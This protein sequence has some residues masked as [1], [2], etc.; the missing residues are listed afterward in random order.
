MRPPPPA[1]VLPSRNE[2]TTIAAVTAAV[3]AALDN[4][5][6][7]I[8]H[9]DSS[10]THETAEAF[11]RTSTRA[12]KVT[13]TGLPRGKGIQILRALDW[14][15]SSTGPVLIADTDTRDPDPTIYK[16]LL[17]VVSGGAVMAIADYPRFWD[18]AN[19]TNH[20]ARPLIDAALGVDIPQ[21]LAGDLA[22]SSGTLTTLP[23]AR[24]ALA[25]PEATAVEGYGIDA[26]LLLT[27]ARTGTVTPVRVNTPKRH[28]ASFE[29]LAAIYAQV[30]PILL[31]MTAVRPVSP[32]AVGP[33]PVY[34]ATFRSVDLDRLR[35]MVAALD[36]VAPYEP[37]YD[38]HP[39]PMPLA[40]AW[41]AVRT[42]TSPTRA[43]CTLWPHYV[44]R[45][46]TWLI[47]Q[48]GAGELS[49]S[50]TRLKAA[51]SAPA[52]APARSRT[53]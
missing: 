52:P 8:V 4:P 18:E 27:A 35:T 22:L 1:A 20:I 11:S 21:P 5:K 31:A 39:W 43:A 50:H 48:P 6:A 15:S 33:D 40:D 17:D 30:V 41:H 23:A 7:V 53:P 12:R 44:H 10:D 24:R 38:A 37:S 29:H 47:A 26:F 34:R 2:P 28:A 49:A 42:G 14:L 25:N 13:L 45:V 36:D 19:L 16:A 46:R 3:D 9:A 51:L 32:P